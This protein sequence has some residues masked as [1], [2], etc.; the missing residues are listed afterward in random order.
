[1][2]TLPTSHEIYLKYEHLA[3]FYARKI[4]NAGHISMDLKDL[5]QEFKLKLYSSILSYGNRWADFL[6]GKV[7][8]PVPL[9][10]YLKLACVNK[11]KDFIKF[12]N[13][14]QA[15][16]PIDG[17][18]FDYGIEDS[19]VDIER[20][21][22]AI[23]DIDL[24][25]GLNDKEKKIFVLHLKG[26]KLFTIKKVLKNEEKGTTIERVIREQSNKLR[27]YKDL[28]LEKK[29]LTKVENFEQEQSY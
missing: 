27:G 10:Y 17:L 1:M 9:K 15:M 16:L 25:Q 11:V 20:G 14:E 28:L 4:F 29:D 5:E 21:V 3:K 26:F 23:N 2:K 22:Y 12:I 13:R 6:E 8:R 24:L 18:S 19:S 7:S